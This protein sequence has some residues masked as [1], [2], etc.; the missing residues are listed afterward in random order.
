MSFD[1]FLPQ[2]LKPQFVLSFIKHGSFL[3]RTELTILFLQSNSFTDIFFKMANYFF[4]SQDNF[5]VN[6]G[7]N[8]SRIK[9]HQTF[10]LVNVVSIMARYYKI[11]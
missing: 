1:P 4:L 2:Q 9:N 8:R 11:G 3:N 6:N 10:Q 5:E 7:I